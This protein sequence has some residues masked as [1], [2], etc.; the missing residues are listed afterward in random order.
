MKVRHS[1][2]PWDCLKAGLWADERAASWV[3]P[4]VYARAGPWAVS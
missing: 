1:A 3:D 4:L 2:A